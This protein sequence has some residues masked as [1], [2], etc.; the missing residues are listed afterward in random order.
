MPDP[1]DTACSKSLDRKACDFIESRLAA[2]GKQH[3][4]NLRLVLE[5]CQVAGETCLDIGAGAGLFAG[6]M[7]EKGASVSGIEPQ[8][9]FREF[10]EKKFGV[11]L[12]PETIDHPYWQQGRSGQFGVVTLWD[13]LEHVNFPAETLT[14]AYKVTRPGGWLFLDTPCRDSVFYKLSEW[15]YRF[16]GGSNSMLLESLYSAQPFRHKQI[17]TQKQLVRLVE[18]IGWE[19]IRIKSAPLTVQ[20]KIVMAC[21]KPL[22]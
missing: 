15:A 17:F 7:A 6:L 3:R 8:A 16:S 1:E 19:V 9:V 22:P 21:R 14:D 20:N 13:V 4:K 18:R 10:A 2:N 12:R 5:H 11:S